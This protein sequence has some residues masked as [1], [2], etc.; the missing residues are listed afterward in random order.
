MTPE[1]DRNSKKSA[2]EPVT[3]LSNT[4]STPA[5][6]KTAIMDKNTTPRLDHKSGDAESFQDTQVPIVHLLTLK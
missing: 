1:D 2:H 6:L 5:S 4:G 3:N